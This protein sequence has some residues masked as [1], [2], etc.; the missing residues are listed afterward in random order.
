[1][2]DDASDVP[3]ATRFASDARK[4]FEAWKLD[5]GHA[6]STLDRKRQARIEARLR[7]GFTADELILAIT[8]RRNDPWLMGTAEGATRVFDG[9]ETL[10]RDASQVERLRDLEKPL[11]TVRRGP[12]PVQKD[13]PNNPCFG[14]QDLRIVR[15]SDSAGVS[16]DDFAF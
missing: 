2:P 12:G 13:R 4:V 8:H 7:E 15:S 11:Q 1:L 5:T 14:V 6:R 10:L 9:I 3:P 16:L